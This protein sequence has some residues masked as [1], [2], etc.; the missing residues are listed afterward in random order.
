MN[1]KGQKKSAQPVAA[2]QDIYSWQ[3]INAHQEKVQGFMEATSPELVQAKLKQQAIVPVRVKKQVHRWSG[4]KRKPAAKDIAVFARQLATL[5]NAGVPLVQALDICIAGQTTNGMRNLLVAV[6]AQVAAGSSVAQALR[7]QPQYFDALFCSLVEAGENS[8]TLEVMLE[9]VAAY[10]ERM[11]SL[12]NRVKKALYYPAFVLLLGLIVTA[13][14]LLQVVPEFEQMFAGFG[15]DLPWFTQQVVDLAYLMQQG[16]YVPV[17]FVGGAS[18]MLLWMA[19]RSAAVSLKLQRYVLH[20]PLLGR[21]LRQVVIA[22]FARTLATSFAAGVTLVAAVGAAG[23]AT[24]NQF[25]AQELTKVAA[26]VASGQ[27]LS[28]CL[29]SSGIFPALV[30]QL[31]AVGEESGSLDSLLVKV[32]EYYEEEVN[33]QVASLTSLLEPIVLVVLGVLVGGVVV[34]M[35]LPIFQMGAIL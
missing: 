33:T 23:K 30:C 35:Y 7:Q 32:A 15:A 29:R 21:L 17:V 28:F 20:V 12:K 13:V 4:G 14:L 25:Y 26:A 27:K 18:Y 8:G 6:R 2:R 24:G 19:R 22:R 9:R 34:A 11:E 10:K 16:W 5:I 1:S 31:V 3:G